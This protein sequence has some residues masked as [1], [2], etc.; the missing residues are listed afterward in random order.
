[1]VRQR[2]QRDRRMSLCLHSSSADQKGLIF[3]YSQDTVMD[4]LAKIFKI[5]KNATLVVRAVDG[6]GSVGRAAE[7]SSDKI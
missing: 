4:T 7:Q 2:G 5:A 6:C 3:I 1:M